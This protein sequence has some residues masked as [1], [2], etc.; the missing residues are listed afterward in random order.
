MTYLPDLPGTAPP[1]GQTSLRLQNR[2][3][4]TEMMV[5]IVE[6]ASEAL[7]ESIT[8]TPRTD[9]CCRTMENACVP[10]DRQSSQKNPNI[11]GRTSS[12]VVGTQ[13]SVSSVQ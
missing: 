2:L 12:L 3:N 4:A 5:V 6:V 8:D 10:P 11:P 7:P 9:Q 1:P 13:S